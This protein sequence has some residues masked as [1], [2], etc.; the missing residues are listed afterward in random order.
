MIRPGWRRATA[1]GVKLVR[2]PH[3][4]R[5]QSGGHRGAGPQARL[6]SRPI[7]RLH[8][9]QGPGAGGRRT[10]RSASSPPSMPSESRASGAC[11]GRGRPCRHRADGAAQGRPDRRAPR[12][13]WRW[14][15]I[16]GAQRTGGRYGR[17]AFRPEPGATNVVPGSGRVHHRLSAVARR[18]RRSL[19]WPAQIQRRASPRSL[20]RARRRAGRSSPYARADGRADGRCQAAGCAS[21][22]GIARSGSQ[23]RTAR[24]LPSGAGHDAMA[25]AQVALPVSHAL[26]AQREGHQPLAAGEHERGR[27]RHR[28][29]RLSSKP[30]LELARRDSQ[31]DPDSRPGATP[32]AIPPG[33]R[34]RPRRGAGRR[35]LAMDFESFFRDRAGRIAQRRPLSRLR[36]PGTPGRP[37]SRSRPIM[38]TAARVTITVWCSNDYLG[39]GQHPKV[40]AAMHQAHSIRQRCRRW[41]DAQYRRHQPLPCPAGAASL[42]TCTARKPR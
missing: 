35:R 33:A 36:R 6:G 28:H 1:E 26:R 12:W 19:R 5:R 13:R 34:T 37:A 29:P 3:C 22:A 10:S 7:S 2:S 24:R 23:S 40:L 17:R 25:I 14:R 41:W 9:E 16:A 8:I 30:I 38:A 20:Q 18:T 15:Q 21:A 32:R 31:L 11:H 27:C 42:P 39:M 4:L